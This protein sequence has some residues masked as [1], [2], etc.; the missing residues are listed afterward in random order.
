VIVSSYSGETEESLSAFLDAKKRG[1]MVFCVSSGGSLLKYAEALGVPFLRVPVGMP[2]RAALP[3]ILISLL[4]C[5]E[6]L[7]L[8]SGVSEEVT[9]ATEVLKQVAD[10]YSPTVASKDNLAKTLAIAFNGSVPTIYGF[11]IYRSVSRRFKQQ[12][13]E[14]GKNPAKWDIFPELDHN[15]IVGWENAKDT[16]QF[17]SVI[18]IEDNDASKAIDSRINITKQLMQNSGAKLFTI[19]SQGKTPLAKMLSVICLGDFA[20]VYLA[21][22]REVDPTPVETINQLKSA[23]EKNGVKASIIEGLKQL[24]GNC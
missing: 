23:L 10:S 2:P 17:F 13:N 4:V 24:A 8:T 20:S 15:E 16:A 19:K 22:L 12:I 9:E 18:L 14:N 11:D 21:V 7:G 5:M 1:C 6:K 3:Y